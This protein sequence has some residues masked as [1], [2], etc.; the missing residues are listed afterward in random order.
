[1][2][3]KVAV[4]KPPQISYLHSPLYGEVCENKKTPRALSNFANVTQDT[5]IFLSSKVLLEK[6]TIQFLAQ[7][8]NEFPPE[9]KNLDQSF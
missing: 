2:E 1:M 9:D 4:I 7:Q 8:N 3:K 5:V 6:I